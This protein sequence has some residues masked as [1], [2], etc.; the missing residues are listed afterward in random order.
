MSTV[1]EVL[2]WDEER[3]PTAA[4][5]KTQPRPAR[6]AQ[7]GGMERCVLD[8]LADG[9]WTSEKA[10]RQHLRWGRTRF[11]VVTTWLVLTGWIEAREEDSILA[12]EYRLSPAMW[13]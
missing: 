10:L 12:S 5:A 9:V 1:D 13:G 3:D 11:F 2:D 8:A 4:P 6:W 7:L